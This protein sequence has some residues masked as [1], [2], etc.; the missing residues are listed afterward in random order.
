MNVSEVLVMPYIQDEV[1]LDVFQKLCAD[2][3]IV[4][5]QDLMHYVKNTWITFTI[6]PLSMWL[7]YGCNVWPNNDVERWH[8]LLN[9]KV[10]YNWPHCTMKPPRW[11]C[12]L[13]LSGKFSFTVSETQIHL[14]PGS[15]IRIAGQIHCLIVVC[16]QLF[17]G[18]SPMH[19]RCQQELAAVIVDFVACVSSTIT[20]LATYNVVIIFPLLGDKL[21]QQWH[22]RSSLRIT[23]LQLDD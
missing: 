8:F 4:P 9:S 21:C 7:V 10:G 1:A 16:W 22:Y 23:G 15:D 17:E 13:C 12:R 3:T 6:W 14:D 11:Q 18:C 2:A 5:L 19:G 20:M